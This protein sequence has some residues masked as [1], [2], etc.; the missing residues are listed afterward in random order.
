MTSLSHATPDTTVSS[1]VHPGHRIP[2]DVN[3]GLRYF[4]EEEL[5]A[6]RRQDEVV[7]IARPTEEERQ[8]RADAYISAGRSLGLDADAFVASLRD[9]RAK[10]TDRLAKTDLIVSRHPVNLTPLD[11]EP[12]HPERID[13]SFWWARTDWFNPGDFR[14]DFRSDGLHFTR[15]ITHHSGSLRIDRF[16]MVAAFE[17]QPARI[18]HSASRRWRS[19]PYVELFGGVLGRTGDNDI[20]TGDL[21]SKCWMFRRQTLL[22]FGLGP[23]GPVPIIIGEGRDSQLLIF[24]ENQDR[25]VRA[26]MPG[27][28]W[29]PPVDFGNINMA[30]SLWVHLEVRF[31][32]QIEGAGSLLWTDPEVL[33]RAFQWPLIPL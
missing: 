18:P 29:M 23:T 15:G 10:K 13:N 26:G 8:A 1:I 9:V 3:D 30:S 7:R 6:V 19:T 31:D 27:F 24:E 16:G 28:Q 14:A 12:V 11:L 21:W 17:L 5:A 32:I 25:T 33:I 4:Q 22:Q 20:T 2:N